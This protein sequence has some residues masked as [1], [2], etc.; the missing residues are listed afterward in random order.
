[1]HQVLCSAVDHTQIPEI[2]FHLI[3]LKSSLSG[4]ISIL[5]ATPFQSFAF[6]L[7]NSEF[8]G[9]LAVHS[10]AF[11][12]FFFPFF[13]LFLLKKLPVYIKDQLRNS[14]KGRDAQDKVQ[15]EGIGAELSYPVQCTTFQLPSMS[16]SLPTWKLLLLFP[17]YFHLFF[18]ILS[19]GIFLLPCPSTG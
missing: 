16:V 15:G 9:Q 5:V 10:C 1:M 6:S 3:S 14:P 11:F 17:S 7:Y 12:F 8:G 2:Q 4:S 18:F 19:N 13:F